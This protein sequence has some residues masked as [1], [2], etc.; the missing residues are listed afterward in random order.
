MTPGSGHRE[1][2]QQTV[3][4][5]DGSIYVERKLAERCAD[6]RRARCRAEGAGR[7]AERKRGSTRRAARPLRGRVRIPPRGHRRRADMADGP[8]HPLHA[9][10]GTRLRGACAPHDRHRPGGA[11]RHRRRPE[12]GLHPVHPARASGNGAGRRTVELSAPDGGERRCSRADGRQRGGAEAFAPDAALRRADGAGVR[13]R[14]ACRRGCSRRCT[15][16]TRR[17]RK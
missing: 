1:A 15:C 17:R 4:P 14:R 13:T 5:V 2:V 6:R 11:G 16:R 9:R 3:S 10:R 8:A 7:V 12:R